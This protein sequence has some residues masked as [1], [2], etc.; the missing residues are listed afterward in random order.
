MACGIYFPKQ[1]L[2]DLATQLPGKSLQIHFEIRK[3]RPRDMQEGRRSLRMLYRVRVGAG[4]GAE[5]HRGPQERRS[6]V[7]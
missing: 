3:E 2:G 1:E 7:G 4:M 5:G 6:R